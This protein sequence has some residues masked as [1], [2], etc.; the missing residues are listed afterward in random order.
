M[1]ILTWEKGFVLF[2]IQFLTP[3]R[4]DALK[5]LSFAEPSDK[6][7]KALKAL[8]RCYMSLTWE[9]FSAIRGQSDQSCAQSR[10]MWSSLSS[11]VHLQAIA[12]VNMRKSADDLQM[13]IKVNRTPLT[14]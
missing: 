5:P 8:I 12:W 4:S 10:R 14:F 2:M 7:E 11:G 13:N 3:T 6:N 1:R 9:K